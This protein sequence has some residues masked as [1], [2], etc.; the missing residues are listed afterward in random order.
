[1]WPKPHPNLPDPIIWPQPHYPGSG[2]TGGY[3]PWDI[4]KLK[5]YLELLKEVKALE[6]SIGGCPCPEERNKANHI[7]ILEDRIDELEAKLG[8]VKEIIIEKEGP[9][10]VTIADGTTSN[11]PLKLT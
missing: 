10:T 9:K 4:T 1:M 2:G 3:Q 11:P 5:E 6:D 7:K 8:K